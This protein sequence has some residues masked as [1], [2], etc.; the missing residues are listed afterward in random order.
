MS[1]DFIFTI[2]GTVYTW[3]SITLE[4]MK[5]TSAG[6]LGSILS[7]IGTISLAA[8]AL[9]W[10][11]QKRIEKKSD[12][13]EYALDNLYVFSEEVGN[14]LKFANSWIVY[15]RHSEG[16]IQKLNSLSENE[17]REFVTFLNNDPYE[18]SNYYK[19]GI[20]IVK[21]LKAVIYRSKRL[22]DKTIDDKL[23]QLND[24]V[25]ELPNRLMDMHFTPNPKEIKIAAKEYL[26]DSFEIIE[27]DC[28]V[29]HDLLLDYLMFKRKK[30]S[31]FRMQFHRLKK[32]WLNPWCKTTQRVNT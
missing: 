15:S 7:G 26:Q 22:F 13:A 21:I 14:W 8:L 20:E 25:Q 16:N 29:V 23:N 3:F 11:W 18:A 31:W 24:R 1:F 17:K 9:A 6:N 10:T 12:I 32:I 2:A 27:K 28:L 30:F 19:S 4:A 5:S